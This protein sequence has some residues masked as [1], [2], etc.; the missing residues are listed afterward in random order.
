MKYK[1][2]AEVKRA[3][4][5]ESWR[6]LSKD[7]IVRFAAMM[8]DM[9]TEV[10]LKIVEQFPVFKQFALDALDGIEKQ[11][12]STLGHN[13]SSQDQT[14]LAFQ[15]TRALLKEELDREGL[16]WEERK[17]ILEMIMS[18]A[19]L[20][21]DK[22]SENKRFL[23]AMFEKGGMIALGALTLGVAFVGGK[24]ALQRGE[25]SETSTES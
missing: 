23:G 1:N 9:D 17:H 10:A 4:D 8:P 11:H 3:L 16:T 7:K 12:A 20:E 25:D 5:I 15:E 13:K 6:N 2:E 22:D 14:H 24:F 21:S 18:L 19:S